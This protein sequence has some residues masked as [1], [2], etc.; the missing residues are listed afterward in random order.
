MQLGDGSAHQLI[1][2]SKK[3]AQPPGPRVTYGTLVIKTTAATHRIR[4]WPESAH[5]EGVRAFAMGFAPSEFQAD[6]FPGKTA[7][8]GADFQAGAGPRHLGL[9]Q[10]SK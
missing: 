2:Q 5:A 3:M 7:S 10:L 6:I 4:S 8:A 9:L 1:E